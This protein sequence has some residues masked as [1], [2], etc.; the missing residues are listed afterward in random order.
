MLQMA[1]KLKHKTQKRKTAG[2][3]LEEL[4]AWSKMPTQDDFARK[5]DKTRHTYLRQIKYDRMPV[6]DAIKICDAYNIPYKYFDGEYEL[7]SNYDKVS[8]GSVDYGKDASKI[9]EDLRNQL[10]EAQKTIIEQAQTINALVNRLG[11]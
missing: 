3:L 2:E 4:Y 10:S 6:S 5:Y 8:E 1:E 9:I 7:P 11:N